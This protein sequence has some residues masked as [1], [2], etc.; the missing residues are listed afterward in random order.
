MRK[1]V[2]TAV[3]VALIY[4]YS[5]Y[6]G[7][8]ST[9][10]AYVYIPKT[11]RV[12]LVTLAPNLKYCDK[13]IPLIPFKRCKASLVVDVEYL[14]KLDDKLRDMK[15]QEE[16]PKE[17]L[18]NLMARTKASIAGEIEPTQEERD[19]SMATFWS[20][21]YYANGTVTLAEILPSTLMPLLNNS[22]SGPVGIF[23]V[24]LAIFKSGVD[25]KRADAELF[26]NAIFFRDEGA[27]RFVEFIDPHLISLSEK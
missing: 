3:T 13:W 16:H 1:H 10:Q 9:E 25:K 14:W 7:F 8:F 5:V 22:G 2:W 4:A 11:E 26:E 15:F 27:R 18:D 20:I 17:Y 24:D 19:R 21:E 23:P 6:Q 12:F